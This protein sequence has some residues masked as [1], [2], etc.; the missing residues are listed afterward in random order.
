MSLSLILTRWVETREIQSKALEKRPAKIF[1]ML[2][3]L[4]PRSIEDKYVAVGGLGRA[5][6]KVPNLKPPFS[7]KKTKTEFSS[8]SNVAEKWIPFSSIS[9]FNKILD[10]LIKPHRF[11]HHCTIHRI[12]LILLKRLLIKKGSSF[13][14]LSYC[15]I[16]LG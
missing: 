15:I 10:K 13:L 5:I 12:I 7:L 11:H 3:F 14:S 9:S 2:V 4:S 1:V 8:F 6:A 16:R